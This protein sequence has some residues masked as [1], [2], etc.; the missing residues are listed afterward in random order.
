MDILTKTE[1][2]LKYHGMSVDDVVIDEICESML[3]EMEAGLKAEESSLEMIPTYV[4]VPEC[5]ASL[6][7]VVVIDAGGT[8]FRAALAQFSES[9]E[10]QVHSLVKTVMPGAERYLS[11]DEFFRAMADIVRD[12]IEESNKIGFCFSYP[13]EIY[14]N[15]DGCLIRFVKEIKAPDVEGELIGENLLLTLGVKKKIVILN[16]TVATL[17][18]GKATSVTKSYSSYVGFILGTGCN[19]SYI[20]ACHNIGKLSEDKGHQ[21]INAELGNFNQLDRGLIDIELDESTENPG[22][23]SFEKMISGRYLGELA[24]RTLRKAADERLINKEI[25]KGLKDISNIETRDLNDFLI[26]PEGG[27]ILADVCGK[28]GTDSRE[29]FYYIASNLVKRAAKLSAGALSALCLKSGADSSATRPI[30]ITAEGSTFYML[31]NL[32]EHTLSY[33][34]NSLTEQ[35]GVYTEIFSVEDATFKGA[36]IA[37]LS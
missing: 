2:F 13:T 1:S 11:K 12:L 27:N 17:L 30:C 37:A 19:G 18:A 31:K 14:P 33:L 7:P 35:N 16:D 20:E 6:D 9:G 8:N 21:I 22:I 24:L 26:S 29:I 28:E 5:V 23:N 36:A 15:G 34:D 10:F 32:R 3:S 4:D 25:G